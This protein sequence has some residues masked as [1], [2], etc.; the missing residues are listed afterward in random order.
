M[1]AKKV[2]IYLI[3][4]LIICAGCSEKNLIEPSTDAKDTKIESVPEETIPTPPIEE[5]VE[6]DVVG[7]IINA[8]SNEEL[9][10]QMLVFHLRGITAPEEHFAELI[11]NTYCSNFLLLQSNCVNI[12]QLA[13]LV[14]ETKNLNPKP[15]IPF[16]FCIDEEGGRVAR[17][18]LGLPSARTTALS[19]EPLLTA[20]QNGETTALALKQAG[21]QLC[22]APVLDTAKDLNTASLGDRIYDSNPDVASELGASFIK[23][24]NDNGIAATIK[25]F[26]GVGNSSIDSHFAYPIISGTREELE[27]YD[28]KSF[29]NALNDGADVIMV[30]HLM[31]PAFDEVN[32]SSL[33]KAITTDLLRNEWGFDGVVITDDM[34][35][36]SITS[37]YDI[38]EASLQALLAGADMLMITEYEQHTYDRLISAVRDGTITRERLEESARR[39]LELK[40][41]YP[42]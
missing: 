42:E 21:V 29:R 6:V 27:A 26:P 38:A 39:I 41:K 23:G 17:L 30:G 10:G 14:S 31:M 8:M 2:I 40:W 19:D 24:L 12:E 32:P 9:L 33:S 22:L 4:I 37:N 15:E 25:H 11:K 35:M 18:G 16:W 20:Y 13:G 3:A 1:K 34:L 28:L 5:E 36:G 7:E